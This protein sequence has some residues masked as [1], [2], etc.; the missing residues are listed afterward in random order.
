MQATVTTSADGTTEHVPMSP[1]ALAEIK[2]RHRKETTDSDSGSE[3][4]YCPACWSI[5]RNHD[6]PGYI[7][8]S[9]LWPCDAALFATRIDEMEKE[10]QV[11]EHGLRIILREHRELS[12]TGR[13]RVCGT[14]E[15]LY[16]C[17]TALD[18]LAALGEAQ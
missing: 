15:G 3:E 8:E 17:L 13:C 5:R 2:A 1:E 6:A 11:M 12:T 9:T 7:F 10:K 16:P 18:A 14:N 4:D